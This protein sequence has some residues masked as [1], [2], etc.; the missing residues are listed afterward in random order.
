MAGDNEING[1]NQKRKRG[2][3]IV[4]CSAKGGIGRTV[5]TVN[6]AVALS[7]NNIQIG[8]MDGNF[9]FGDI[10]LALDLQPTFTI[11]DVVD[12][13]SEMDSFGLS[14]YLMRHSSGV[15]VLAAPERPEYADLVTSDVVDKVCDLMLQQHDY[16]IVDTGVGLQDR[17]LQFIEKA[18]QIFVLTNLEM[19]TMKNTKLMLE[20]LDM[21]G[22]GDKVEVVVN[23][24]NMESVIQASDVSDIL[25]ADTP[26]FIPN[27]FQLVSQ[28]L[29]I[30]VPFVMNHAKTDLAKAVF[31]MAE[32]LIARRE[33]T[34]FKPK[35]PSLFQ[36]LFQKTK[37]T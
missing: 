8:V 1:S 19:A 31:K 23:R 27:Q 36:A 6:L 5:L 33:I 18:D 24:S 21:L 11:K 37:T 35:P 30:G 20:T 29:N 3:M 13:I 2:E 16:L 10:C 15:K 9:Q 25:D 26:F 32:Q 14:G 17:S 7:K 4:V 34:L 12:N 22:L 28:S